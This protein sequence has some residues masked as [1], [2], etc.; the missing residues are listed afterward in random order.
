MVSEHGSGELELD[1]MSLEVFF[2]ISDSM[3]L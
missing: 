2:N 3:I 1:W